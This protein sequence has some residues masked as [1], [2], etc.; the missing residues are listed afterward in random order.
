MTGIMAFTKELVIVEDR[1]DMLTR[2]GMRK[3]GAILLLNS[4]ILA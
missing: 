2:V 3:K 1:P 4:Q